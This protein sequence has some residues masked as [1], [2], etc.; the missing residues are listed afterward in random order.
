M[1]RLTFGI[2]APWSL[3]HL[4]VGRAAGVGSRSYPRGPGGSWTVPRDRVAIVSSAD[5]SEDVARVVAALRDALPLDTSRCR[6]RAVGRDDVVAVHAYRGLPEV[7][8]FLGHP[9][10]DR[11]QAGDLVAD[12]LGDGTAVTVLC[13]VD[14]L[15]VG[16][17]R[18]W[19][20][21][22]AAMR[23]ATTTQVEAGLGYAFHPRAHGRGL[24]TECV[25][26]VLE[27]VLEPGGVRRVTAR[28]F[29]PASA[30]SRL[31]GRLGFTRDGV[32]RAAVLAP[33][34]RTWWDDE[35]WSRLAGEGNPEGRRQRTVRVDAR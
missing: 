1:P 26:A 12:W 23:P 17:V 18:L 10:L 8:R 4:A 22:S 30:S 33:D 21:R 7:T 13:E 24:A 31:L 25:G 3:V 9:P 6:L 27:L 16:D 34:G 2:P 19:F 28:V 5:Q 35:L 20:R 29:A 11:Q 14:G 32:D 15:V